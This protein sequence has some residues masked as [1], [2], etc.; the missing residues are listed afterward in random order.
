MHVD[1]AS[2]SSGLLSFADNG[3][4]GESHFFPSISDAQLLDQTVGS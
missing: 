1:E 3:D 2:S 4:K